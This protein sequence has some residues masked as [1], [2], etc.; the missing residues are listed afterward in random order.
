MIKLRVQRWELK[1]PCSIERRETGD[2]ML[3]KKPVG[4]YG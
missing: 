4:S 2:I 3:L 1:E